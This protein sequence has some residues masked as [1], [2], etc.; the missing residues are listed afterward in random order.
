MLY[1]LKKEVETSV[2]DE[3]IQV[4]GG[5]DGQVTR[6][7]I[8]NFTEQEKQSVINLGDFSAQTVKIFRSDEDC[9]FEEEILP[10]KGT[11]IS[12]NIKGNAV[13]VVELL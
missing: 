11:N 5:Y 10:D 13:Y 1:A 2:D 8:S 7:M 9:S 3:D 6:L 12:L 4:L